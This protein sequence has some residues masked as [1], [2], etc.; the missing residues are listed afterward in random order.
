MVQ[1]RESELRITSAIANR[2]APS[3]DDRIR[4]VPSTCDGATFSTWRRVED[5]EGH[6]LGYVVIFSGVGGWGFRFGGWDLTRRLKLSGGIAAKCF[7]VFWRIHARSFDTCGSMSSCI[8]AQGKCEA[9]S[10]HVFS[11]GHFCYRW[12]RIFTRKPSIGTVFNRC[13]FS[14]EPLIDNII[15][16]TKYLPRD[17]PDH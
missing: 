7:S 2:E 11:R 13:V 14:C 5:F 17:F 3:I 4:S 9:L 6:G 1:M 8:L 16:A 10:L 15:N 12:S